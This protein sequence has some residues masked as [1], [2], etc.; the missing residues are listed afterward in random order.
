MILSRRSFLIAG[1]ATA[2]TAA[3]GFAQTP[4]VPRDFRIGFQK[5]GAIVVAKQQGAIEQRLKAL[6][7]EAV[8]WLEFQSG[9]PL[10]EALSVGS[11]DF[12]TTGDT[13]PIF[14]QAAGADLVYAATIPQASSAVL[15]PETS[16]ITAVCGAQGQA[17]RLHQGVELAQLHRSGAQEGRP[18]LHRRSRRS[19]SARPMRRRPSPA[20]RSMRGRSGTPS[21]LSRRRTRRRGRSPASRA[22]VA[23]QFLL[24]RQPPLRRRASRHPQGGHRRTGAGRRLGRGEPGRLAEILAEVTG[25]DLEAQRV[26]VSRARYGVGPLTRR[27]DRQA[28][29]HR[30]RVP[31]RSA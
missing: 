7:V 26:A 23:Q 8:K 18:R 12:G 9:P 27:G 15:V 6:G 25:V 30:R 10:L 19:I 17:H 22:I 16:A 13:P 20:A 2:A 5:S 14:A 31:P 11:V 3:R 29:A 24:S 4:A 21:S 1:A 28:A